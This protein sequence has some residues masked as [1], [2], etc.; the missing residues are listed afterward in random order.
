M[1]FHRLCS[2]CTR[3]FEVHSKPVKNERGIALFMVLGAIALITMLATE[4][5]YVAQ[6]N[7]R[8]SYDGMDQVRAFYLAKS[9][10]KLSLLRLKAYQNIKKAVDKMGGAQASSMVPK[11]MLDQIW[12]FPFFYP[13][14]ANVPGLD[15]AQRSSIEKFQKASVLD[16]KYSMVIES[17]SSKININQFLAPYSGISTSTQPSANPTASPSPVASF[18][19]EEAKRS[20]AEFF[21]AMLATAFEQDEEF[22]RQNRDFRVED[23][24][25]HLLGWIDRNHER[26]LVNGRDPA[27]FKKAPMVSISEFH[28]LPMMNDSLYNIF[29]PSLTASS[30]RGININT[31]KEPTLRALVPGIDAEEVK[32]FFKFRDAEDDDNFFKNEGAFFTYLLKNVKAFRNDQSELDRYKEEL[33]RKQVRLITDENEFKITATGTFNQAKK[34]IEVWVTLGDSSTAAQPNSPPGIPPPPPGTSQVPGMPPPISGP[35]GSG[36]K[37][38]NTG[39]RVTFMRIL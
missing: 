7:R 24:M 3:I 21:S 38:P 29:A 23:F 27:T 1:R 19:P 11:R 4:F 2:F 34:V 13:I 33:K 16:G 10:F 18:N 37:P 31:L 39:L 22:A 32:E 5:T 9:A 12:A 36:T 8:I 20:L 14:P 28:Q 35:G 25:D 30:T 26:R 15:L 17:E 6:V